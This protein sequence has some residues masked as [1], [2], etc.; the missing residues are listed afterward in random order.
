MKRA[1]WL[2]LYAGIPP[3]F[4]WIVCEALGI[5][6][7]L[8]ALVVLSV[9][10]VAVAAAFDVL[11]R[12]LTNIWIVSPGG[13]IGTVIICWAALE[14]AESNIEVGPYIVMFASAF[15][16]NILVQRGNRRRRDA[17]KG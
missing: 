17:R 1:A 5:A 15:L 14:I 16:A 11:E 7:G 12:R 8:G 10:T 9:V 3:F 2:G 13:A 6:V 4:F